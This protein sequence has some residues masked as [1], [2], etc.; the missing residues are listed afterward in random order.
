MMNRRQFVMAGSAAAA[1][2]MTACN[3]RPKASTS[4]GEVKTGGARMIP[5]DGGRYRVWTKRVGE[6]NIKVLTLHGGPGGN[7]MYLECMEDFLPREGIE[8]YYHD[9]LGGGFSDN[10]D[11]P[12]LWTVARYTNEVEQVR[13]ALG[14]QDFYLYG[15]S[16]GGMLGYEYALKYGRNLKGLVISNMVASMPQYVRYV[17]KLRNE[18]PP[19]AI[20]TMQKYEAK[21][22]YEAPEYQK[23]LMEQVYARHLCRLDPWPEPAERYLRYLNTK[24]YNYMQGPSELTVTGTYKDWDRTGDLKDIRTR[25]LLIGARYD[26]MDPEEMKRIAS[27]MPNAR[28]AISEKGSHCTLY[29]DQQWYFEELIRFLKG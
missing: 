4:P 10:P 6:G 22:A 5:I 9:Q 23:I 7:H 20:A 14:L 29:D 19:D 24:I 13:Q 28:V 27:T 11:D 21:G 15:H 25:A 26:T 12:S 2:A 18:L 17:N 1:L 3:R 8:F 16:F